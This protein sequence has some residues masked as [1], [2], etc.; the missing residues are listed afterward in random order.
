MPGRSA[1]S[2]V[3]LLTLLGVC[4]GGAAAT[5]EQPSKQ[6]LTGPWLGGDDFGPPWTDAS[7]NQSSGAPL[8]TFYM[9]RAVSD[10]H[11][12]P[13]N[14]NAGN[15]AGVLWYLHHEVVVQA[16]RKFNIR[17]IM[18]YK[19][20]MRAT[21][22]L[23]RL[24]MHFGTRLAFDR[25]QATGPF[26]CGKDKDAPKP[27]FADGPFKN[28]CLSKLGEF[29]HPFEWEKFGYFVGC[30]KLGEFPFPEYAVAYPNAIWYSLPGECPSRPF[31]QRDGKCRSN[32]PGGY[33]PGVVP[34]GNGTCT[35]NYEEAGEITIDELVGIQ[36][37]N[38]FQNSNKR[39]YDP[40]GDRGYNFWWWDNI[41]SPNRSA[42]R[43][44]SARKLFEAKYPDLET[45]E[46][47]GEPPCDFKYNAFYREWFLRDVD[48]SA[49]CVSYKPGSECF[50][51]AL[52]AKNDGMATH[53]EWYAGLSTGSRIQ[54]FMRVL[55][56][57]GKGGCNQPPCDA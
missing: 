2:A 22:P 51:S 19:V 44:T 57:Q 8:Y 41:N 16:P 54:D 6:A 18:R 45:E 17:K 32:D 12:P 10:D 33:C 40:Y 1:S 49:P 5:E 4:A 43:V 21:A 30:N 37:Y 9:Y 36:D 3:L 11:Y 34:N 13:L 50:K 48:A 25:G 14:I 53:P 26:V 46:Q 31:Y 55:Y 28:E 27:L 42:E 39:E 38:A 47:L 29:Q 23:A 24:G 15:L 7:L 56:Q 20:Q 35:W 52:W